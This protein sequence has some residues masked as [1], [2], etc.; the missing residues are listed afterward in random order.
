MTAPPSEKGRRYVRFLFLAIGISLVLVVVGYWPTRRLAGLEAVYAQLAGCGISLVSSL[1]GV[2]PLAMVGE[3][4]PQMAL[5]AVLMAMALRLAVVVLLSL[6]VALSDWFAIEP[7]LIWVAISYS[8]LLVID[9]RY[10]LHAM[11]PSGQ[12]RES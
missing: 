6:V 9:T 11:R 7:L 10:A 5:N 1:I 2:V 4:K 3:A 12:E 8:G